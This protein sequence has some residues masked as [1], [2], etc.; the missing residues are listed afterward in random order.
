MEKKIMDKNESIINTFLEEV[1]STNMVRL[2]YYIEIPKPDLKEMI[3]N[4]KKQA[5]T[6]KQIWDDFST[7]LKIENI[8]RKCQELKERRKR[9]GNK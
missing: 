8:E 5:K 3:L 4:P 7:L 6:K 1:S 9:N 2:G